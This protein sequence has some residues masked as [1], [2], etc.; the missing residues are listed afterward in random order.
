MHGL[1]TLVALVCAEIAAVGLAFAWVFIPGIERTAIYPV[2][3]GGS[4]IAGPVAAIWV[5]HW[6]LKRR[7]H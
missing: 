7:E 1:L 2:W 4:M 3:I 6:I 5:G